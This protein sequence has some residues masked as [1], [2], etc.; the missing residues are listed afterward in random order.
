LGCA[1]PQD[2]NLALA[3]PSAASGGDI[4]VKVKDSP[5]SSP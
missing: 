2:G 4:F 1:V 3:L 5:V